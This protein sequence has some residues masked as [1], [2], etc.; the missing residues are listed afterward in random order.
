MVN[1]G[2]SGD[3]VLILTGPAKFQPWFRRF[4]LAAEVEQVWTLYSG[5]EVA[6]QEPDLATISRSDGCKIDG[7]TNPDLVGMA[8][9]NAL[10]KWLGH[11]TRVNIAKLLLAKWLHPLIWEEI[12]NLEPKAAFDHLVHTYKLTDLR[13]QTLGWAKYDRLDF[14]PSQTGVKFLLKARS[15]QRDINEARGECTDTMVIEKV[16]KCLPKNR[17]SAFLTGIKITHDLKTITMSEY[18]QSLAWHEAMC[19]GISNGEKRKKSDKCTGCG[20]WAHT[21]EECWKLHPELRRRRG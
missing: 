15:V 19:G 13:A 20:K 5:E 8:Y 7:K 16:T 4:Q 12:H 6:A 17:F 1:H 10:E 21:V 14:D 9:N 18:L 2:G 11:K 3:E